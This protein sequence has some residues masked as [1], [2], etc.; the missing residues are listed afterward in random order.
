MLSVKNPNSS[1]YLMLTSGS[2]FYI[3]IYIRN[4][5]TRRKYIFFSPCERVSFLFHSLPCL[6]LFCPTRLSPIPL[7][8]LQ[9]PILSFSIS[10]FFLHL[11]FPFL[12]LSNFF[13]VTLFILTH[14]ANL[15]GQGDGY[16]KVKLDKL[17]I[18]LKTSNLPILCFILVPYT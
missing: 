5:L 18:F 16:A 13:I 17:E 10:I 3:Y 14:N 9:S 6:F 1:C 15:W 12:P 8:F 4:P 2:V 7:P 11:H